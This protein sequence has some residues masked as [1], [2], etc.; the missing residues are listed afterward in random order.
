VDNFRAAKIAAAIAIT[1]CLRF[2]ANFA[3]GSCE[4]IGARMILIGML[5]CP[6][7]WPF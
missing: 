6:T 7:E 5:L 2:V 3:H 1:A 4:I